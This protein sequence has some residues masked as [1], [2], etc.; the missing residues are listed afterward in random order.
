[1]AIIKAIE[2]DC[3]NIGFVQVYKGS[4]TWKMPEDA[5]HEALK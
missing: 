5:L 3:G 2:C 1:M 4:I